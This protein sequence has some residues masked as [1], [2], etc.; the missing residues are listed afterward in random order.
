MDNQ[1]KLYLSPIDTA[2]LLH[3]NYKNLYRRDDNGSLFLPW[4]S[5]PAIINGHEY[6][7]KSKSSFF[8][9]FDTF[10]QITDL[11]SIGELRENVFDIGGK[12]VLHA[13]DAR[14]IVKDTFM[15]LVE[16][17]VIEA[18]IENELKEQAAW[19][20]QESKPDPY[21][22]V[23]SFVIG[24]VTYSM[25]HGKIDDYEDWADE[26]IIRTLQAAEPILKNVRRFVGEDT[27]TIH[28][29]NRHGVELIVEKTIDYRI[30]EYERLKELGIIP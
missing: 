7:T 5:K 20:G 21:D 8:S 22:V 25:N 29:V 17:G 4:K 9:N 11:G 2:Q 26:G 23:R 13:R 15:P 18:L 16:L 14:L 12:L 6:F 27:Y 28:T 1:K 10:T 24:P 19:L 30:S 3:Q